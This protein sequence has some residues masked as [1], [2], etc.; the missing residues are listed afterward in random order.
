MIRDIIGLMKKDLIACWLAGAAL[1][2]LAGPLA[3]AGNGQWT[4]LGWNNLGMHCMDDDY[5]VFSILP[6]FNTVDAQLINAQG[7]LVTS[8]TGITMTY[9]AVADPDGSINASS[10]GKSNFWD[11]SLD[12]YGLACAPETGLAGT[13]MPGPQ[14]LPQPLS[15]SAGMGLF[16]AAGIPII[17]ID[18]KGRRNTYPMM[19][20]VARNSSGS[21]LASSDIVLPVS[22]EMDCRACHSSGAGA[23]AKP[24][25]G[26]VNDP[27]DK[28]DFRLNILRLHDEKQAGKPVYASALAANQYLASGLYDTAVAGTAI[29]CA[30][31]HATEALGSA[32]FTGVPALTRAMHARHAAVVAPSNGLTLD[33]V[34]NRSSCY[35]CHPG[36]A[37]RCLRGAMGAAVAKD[38][39]MEMQCQSC[40]GSMSQVGSPARTG[41]LDEP[42]CGNCHTGTATHNNGQIRYASAFD[43][44]NA[45]R[46]PVDKTFA[47][48]ADT[49]AAGKSLFRF[50]KGH[51]GLQCS[52]CHG[53]THAEFP[54]SHRND[55]L[56]SWR[57]Q[58][59][60]GVIS[61]C[62]ACHATMP[63]T[64]TGGPHGMHPIGPAWASGHGEGL[65]DGGGSLQQCATCHG[66]DFRG[67]VLSRAQADRS[68]STEFGVRVF[69]RGTKISCYG[70]HNGPGSENAS[71]KAVPAVA[72]AKLQ[73]PVNGK[74]SLALTAKA[75][76]ASVRIST[77][78]THGTVSINGLVATYLPDPG[79]IGPDFF[80]YIAADAAGFMESTAAT[81]SVNVGNVTT[82][83]DTDGDGI[84]NLLE[85]AMGLSPDFPSETRKPVQAVETVGGIPYLTLSVNRSIPPPDARLQIQVSADQKT[86]TSATIMTNTPEL[87]KA[88]DSVRYNPAKPRYIRIFMSRP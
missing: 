18:D 80:S 27:N 34:A 71:S 68:F 44:I 72:V 42:G 63:N 14:N 13:R 60:I 54:S 21:V 65:D 52:A 41:W 87:L 5:S 67:T 31:C 69:S 81:V 2:H 20:L 88:R 78:P 9:E 84:T 28:R 11:H 43:L 12:L 49:P 83:L 24:A 75:V 64:V 37:T 74:A 26:W 77:Q 76:G 38:G 16:E 29:L 48:N 30:R 82:L 47:T 59:H 62:T 35:Q 51:G 1:L 61:E 45:L 86:W 23:A 53:S 46:Q 57:T 22:S 39:T 6:P 85:Y 15:W 50:S 73:V 58:G 8:A 32:G 3:F 36:S 4:L 40:H 7:R 55:N 70:C 19:K 66:S 10:A 56:Q 17:P 79:F 25:A 33:A